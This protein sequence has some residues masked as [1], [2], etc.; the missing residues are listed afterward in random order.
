VGAFLST[1]FVDESGRELFRSEREFDYISISLICH[2]L[3][4]TSVGEEK[5]AV[6]EG[7]FPFVLADTRP[8]YRG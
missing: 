1:Q 4:M 3:L 7:T 2:E 8:K 6:A 5:E